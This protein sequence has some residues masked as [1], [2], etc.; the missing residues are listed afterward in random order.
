MK[1]LITAG[2]T[3]TAFK[4]IK[5]FPDHQILLA[6]YG[7]MPVINTGLF[8]FTALG[9]WNEDIL[10]HHLLTKCLDV[11][12]DVLI[13]LYEGEILAVAKSLLLFEEFGV[14]VFVPEPDQQA[15]NSLAE[16][17]KIWCVFSSEQILN[18]VYYFYPLDN[19]FT[20]IQ[21]ANPF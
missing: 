11:G 7:E 3:A 14:K 12:A 10:A 6:D 16:L 2:K 13:P 4:L 17:S 8:D 21:L 19:K 18:G 20:L 5:A 15:G 9:V 1:I